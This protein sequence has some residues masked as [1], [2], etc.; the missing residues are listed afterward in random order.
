M[1]K[2]TD[3]ITVDGYAD[4]RDGEALAARAN[5]VLENSRRIRQSS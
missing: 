5:A 3:M 1:E 2:W 4:V